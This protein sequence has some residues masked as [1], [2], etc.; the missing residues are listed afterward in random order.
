MA[1]R[2]SFDLWLG[3]GLFAASCLL[4]MFVE[5]IP[6]DLRPARWPGPDIIL[7]V[8]LVWVARRPDFVPVWVI[9][10]LFLLCDLMFQRPPGLWTALVVIATEMLRRR[11]GELR[12]MPLLLEWGTV[13]SAI[14]GLVLANRLVHTLVMLDQANLG[15]TLIQT[16]MTIAAYPVV[17]LLA[18]LIFGISRT[19]P[20]QVDSLGHSL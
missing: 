9:V 13:A 7:V 6:L 16:G 2:P 1:E 19:A 15:L 12:N 4:L 5:L 8:T 17:V 10:P 11:Q 14:I 18:H 20:G 3:R